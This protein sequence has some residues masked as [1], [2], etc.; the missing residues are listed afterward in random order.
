MTDQEAIRLIRGMA[1]VAAAKIAGYEAVRTEVEAP[2]AFDPPGRFKVRVFIGQRSTVVAVTG[3][4]VDH[5]LN[6][7]AVREK[8]ER[9]IGAAVAGI[10]R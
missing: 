5:F 6:D 1:L 8:V 10:A 7:K 4:E 2:D 9:R 3:L